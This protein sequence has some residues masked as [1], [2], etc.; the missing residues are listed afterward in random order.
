[1]ISRTFRI[2]PGVGP[3]TEERIISCGVLD[4]YGFLDA[5]SV[6][7][8][9]PRRKAECDRCLETAVGHLEAGETRELAAML[10]GNEEW[11]L[12][13]RFGGDAA[14]LDI[15]TDGLHAG[16]VV[17]M[18]SVHRGGY[19]V[20]LTRGRDLTAG[21][22]SDALDGAPLLV[23]FNGKCFDVPM[24]RGE[25]PGV[26]LGMP[27]MDLRFAGRKAGLRGGLAGVESALG[28]GREGHLARVDGA[29]AVRLWKRWER[30]NDD[31]ALELLTE[32]NRADTENLAAIA[33]IIYGRLSRA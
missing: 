12:F 1:M 5:D 22:L 6:P 11:R 4:W 31:A 10:P 16:A 21:R 29:E 28:I 18:V 24:L 19:T 26:D 9:N 27:N 15:E 23:T 20:T 7:A 14:F 13:G 3:K 8:M 32:Y 17:T 2:L 33:D 30:H 25:F